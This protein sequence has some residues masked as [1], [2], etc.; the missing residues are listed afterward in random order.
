[1]QQQDALVASKNQSSITVAIIGPYNW[2]PGLTFNRYELVGGYESLDIKKYSNL[3]RWNVDSWW[4][5]NQ[6]AVGKGIDHI[7]SDP[8]V[9]PNTTIKIKRF[10]NSRYGM[11]R[12]DPACGIS[13]ANE[14]VN[15][16]PDVVAVFGDFY[17]NDIM[18]SGEVYSHYKIPMC[19]GSAVNPQLL[20]RHNYPYY[21][22]T[23]SLT[24]FAD[25]IA[26]TLQKW[27]VKRVAL[28]DTH[29]FSTS[30]SYCGYISR[31]LESKGF[32]ILAQIVIASLDIIAQTLSH[33][34]ARYIILCSDPGTANYLY[35]S[36]A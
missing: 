9:L 7:N 14:I 31:V 11:G 26:L 4:F 23:A 19:S 28:I 5:W 36:F 10:R 2:L 20:N 1:M 3:T 12:S 35:Y 13:L 29:P 34:D 25:A 18:A 30:G 21:L 24:G 15:K 16:H 6:Y 33:V 27:N 22:Q 32:N 8:T 17:G